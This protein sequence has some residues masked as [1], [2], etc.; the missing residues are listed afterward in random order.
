MTLKSI[1][2]PVLL[3]L[4]AAAPAFAQNAARQLESFAANGNTLEIAVSDGRYLIKPYQEDQ[5]M[6][7]LN[8]VL[9]E[10]RA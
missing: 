7:E 3:T 2:S 9:K 6:D 10:R 1:A 5:L 4:L 8:A